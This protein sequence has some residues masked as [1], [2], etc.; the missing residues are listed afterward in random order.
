MKIHL[1]HVR[2]SFRRADG[3][4]A[5]ALVVEELS[6]AEGSQVCVV[7]GS[8]SGKTTLLNV[9]AGILVPDAGSEVVLGDTD[10]SRLKEGARDKFRAQHVGYVFQTFNLLQ[11]YSAYENVL[12][13]MHFA[14]MRSREA[15]ER[16]RELLGR[17]GLGAKADHRPRA[18]SVGEQ[19]RTAV[20][21]AVACRPAVVLADEPT[22]NLDPS[23]AG[24]ALGVLRDEAAREGA[25][26][27]LVTH[28]D[29]I[30]Q[31]FE[32]VV[33]LEVPR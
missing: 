2:K 20:A 30:Q 21:R 1:K 6:V 17:M 24:A 5:P 10:V 26:L 8:G 11:G 27:I 32:T 25:T 4:L 16:A 22:A 19:Q 33:R 9:I 18:L 28:D 3:T 13:P 29:R 23:N 31:A 7:G 14:G 15:K 12:L